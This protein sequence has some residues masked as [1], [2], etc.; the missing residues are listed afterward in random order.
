M[1]PFL[2]QNGHADTSR[3]K[4]LYEIMGGLGQRSDGAYCRA[5]LQSGQQRLTA[6]MAARRGFS[7]SFAAGGLAPFKVDCA[8]FLAR[9]VR[10]AIDASRAMGHPATT[11]QSIPLFNGLRDREIAHTSLATLADCWVGHF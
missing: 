2:A 4:V 1:S 3:A 9:R 5:S 8:P 10:T 7:Q 11:T 6:W